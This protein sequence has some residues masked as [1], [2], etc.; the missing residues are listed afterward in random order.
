MPA[1]NPASLSEDLTVNTTN[2]ST[3]DVTNAPTDKANDGSTIHDTDD[4]SGMRKRMRSDEF[5]ERVRKRMWKELDDDADVPNLEYTEQN[6]IQRSRSRVREHMER[7][8]ALFFVELAPSSTARGARCQFVD[9]DKRIKE[10]D[11]RIA[12]VP[13]MNNVYQSPGNCFEKL[14]DFWK[15]EY[16][17]R[18]QALT[19]ATVFAR[20]LKLSSMTCGNHLLDGGA[21]RLVL[22]WIDSM[23]RLIAQRDGTEQTLM[24]PKLRDLLN[25][26]G[27]ASFKHEKPDG[28][29]DFE[30][31]KLF[32]LLATIES[33][34]IE[35]KEEWNLIDQFVP[36]S[37]DKLE[38]LN[39]TDSLSSMLRTWNLAQVLVCT[40]EGRLTDGGKRLRAEVD[41]KAARAIR[42]LG[43]IP[44]PDFQSALFDRY[45]SRR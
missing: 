10:G 32:G 35:D 21:E 15:I 43:S 28:M 42:R 6:P 39:E 12:V 33:D 38:D 11:Y 1:H 8:S 7:A 19:R 27:S 34:G 5:I 25:R 20:G 14:V 26:A 16:I 13:G 36:L 3:K 4:S 31:F 30:Y 40:E 29:T 22:Y 9:C 17:K 23:R 45:Y 2:D 18:L 44:M 24:D 41:E 37:F